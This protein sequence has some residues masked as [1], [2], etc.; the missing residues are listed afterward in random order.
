MSG[1]E[2][3]ED[4][5]RPLTKLA[6]AGRRAEWT[7]MPGQPGGIVNPPVWRAS[8]ILYDDV[9]HLRQAARTSTHE[10]LFYGRKGTPTAW[11]L[12][13][14]LTEMEPGAEGTMLFPSGVAAIACALMAVLKP[15][16]QLLM[17]DSA[18]D[19][20]RNFCEQMLRP[21]GI[22]TVYYD[23]TL[24][25]GIADLLTGATRAIFLES[26]GSLTFE[27]QDIPAITALAR[28]KGIVTLADNTWATPIF[29]P[30]LAHGVD[31]SILACTKYIVGHS[32]V[33]MGSVTATPALFPAVQRS[34]YLFGQMTSPDDAWLASRGLR[35]LGVR[36]NQHRD[37]AL[38]VAQWLSGQSGVARVLHPALPSCPGHDIW[39]RDFFGSGGL[40]SFVLEGGDEQ[41][42]AALID[43]LDHF[44]IGYSWGGFESL[45]LPVD[46]ARHRTATRWE[47]E[48]PAVRLN[49]GL[50]DPADLIADLEQ[51]LARFRA[52]RG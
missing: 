38:T 32:D 28:D 15:G 49:I 26:P 45:A 51:G 19:P 6:Q 8:T 27:V 1:K 18:Y 47:A 22:D 23:P 16:D 12:A 52:A 40:F 25:S 37:S 5:R 7:S 46:P 33:M 17:V 48:G 50:E 36:L 13:D 34:A 4:Q 39:R 14:A 20:T 9:A 11:S 3:G 42:R 29:F 43:G 44:G 41:A 21:L 35:T 30:A 10:R 2:G 31:I 24:G